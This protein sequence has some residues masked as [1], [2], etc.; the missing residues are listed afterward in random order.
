M[1]WPLAIYE[2]LKHYFPGEAYVCLLFYAGNSGVA[3]VKPLA[4]VLSACPVG[5]YHNIKISVPSM[6]RPQ[7]YSFLPFTQPWMQLRKQWDMQAHPSV[8]IPLA[9]RASWGLQAL[10][11]DA[12]SISHAVWS[13]S[14]PQHGLWRQLRARSIS[15]APP[16]SRLPASVK[17]LKAALINFSCLSCTLRAGYRVSESTSWTCIRS[18]SKLA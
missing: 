16:Q 14:T 9:S 3:S 4:W 1:I 5:W 10:Y 2:L 13:S 11:G 8:I 18:P 7:M 6:K 12:A 15:R 17:L